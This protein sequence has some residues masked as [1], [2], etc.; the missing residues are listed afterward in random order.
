MVLTGLRWS[1]GLGQFLLPKCAHNSSKSTKQT[2]LDQW[3]ET[4]KKFSFFQQGW[5]WVITIQKH[6]RL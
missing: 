4:A 5:N 6:I 1:P 2:S 3:Q